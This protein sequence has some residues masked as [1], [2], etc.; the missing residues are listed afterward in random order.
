[1]SLP[2]ADSFT[3]VAEPEALLTVDEIAAILKLNQQTVWNGR[4]LPTVH[5]VPATEVQRA[6]T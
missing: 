3:L 4:L 1:M 5:R 6:P 2:A